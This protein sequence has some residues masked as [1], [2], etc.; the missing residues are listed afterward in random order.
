MS[1]Y[2]DHI[3]SGTFSLLYFGNWGEHIL[4]D[5]NNHDAITVTSESLVIDTIK[6]IKT[7]STVCILADDK[8]SKLRGDTEQEEIIREA[9]KWNKNIV[10]LGY[11]GLENITEAIL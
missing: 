10:I 11:R 8:S 5:A 6:Q 2:F 1:N 7:K 3:L 4:D 9:K